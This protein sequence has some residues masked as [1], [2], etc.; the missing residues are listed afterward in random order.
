VV[1]IDPARVGRR[2]QRRRQLVVLEPAVQRA[3][4]RPHERLP[5]AQLTPHASDEVIGE[6]LGDGFALDA[7]RIAEAPHLAPGNGVED[8]GGP[9]AGGPAR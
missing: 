2:P 5:A 7:I 9:S 8:A 4:Q 1:E 3:D 6:R